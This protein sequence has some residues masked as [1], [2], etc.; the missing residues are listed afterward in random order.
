MRRGSIALL[1]LLVRGDAAASPSAGD[2]PQPPSRHDGTTPRKAAAFRAEAGAPLAPPVRRERHDL[3]GAP[4]AGALSGKTVYRSAGPGW[5]YVDGAWHTQRGNTNDLVEDFITVETV[6]QY[7]VPYLRNMGA[8]VV[9]IRESDL[10]TQSVVVDDDQAALEGD[11]AELE[12]ADVG[13]APFTPPIDATVLPFERGGARRMQ[14]TAEETGRAVF[15]IAVA[16]TG[17]YNVYVSYVQGADRAPDAHYVVQH[18]G[19]ASHL[20]VDQRRHGSTGVLLGRWWF[21]AGAPPE[22]SS[23]AVANDSASPGAIISLD[24]VRVGGGAGVHDVGGGV[25]GRPAFESSA[26][27]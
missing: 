22:R 10:S 26:R 19:G 17:T 9:P 14:A 27:Y 2:G 21:E 23:I 8:Y 11:A 4:T 7:L 16:E 18:G 13:F 6:N 24:A 5:T 15:P 3:H 1:L 12:S 20:R 25:T